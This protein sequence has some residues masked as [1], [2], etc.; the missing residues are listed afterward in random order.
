MLTLTLVPIFGLIAMVTD[1]G[2]M[3][4]LKMTAQTAAEAAAQATIIDMHATFGGAT[5]TCA[6]VT[7]SA[8]QTTCP[9]NITTPTNSIQRGCMY[10]QKHGFNSAD[11]WA[12]YQA[13]VSGMPPTMSGMGTASYWVTFRAIQT[14]P[15]MFSAIL[16]NTTG[17]V[18]A[19]ST[20]A[21]LGA[22]D[23]IYSLNPNASGAISA[24]GS[25]S[26]TSACGIYVNSNNAQ[27]LTTS[28]SATIS[29]PEY[30]VAGGVSTH[31]PLSPAANTGV[32]QISD[33]LASLPVPATA[34]YICNHVNYSAPNWSNPTLNPGV[35][36]GGISIGNNSYTLNPGTYILVGGGLS[37]QNA[38]STI[39]GT[40]VMFYNTYNGTYS[41][42]GIS[43]SANS[44]VSIKAPTTGTYAGILF[45][46]DRSA[47][48]TSDNYG[49]GG[50]ATY[51]GVIYAKNA[52]ITMD[53]NS[54]IT[55]NYTLII[56]DTISLIGASGINNNYSALPNGSPI[57]KTVVIE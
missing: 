49:G 56:A 35:Y 47:P 36:C 23:C 15:T 14:V 6:T 33:P 17:M 2:Y 31:S 19:R 44:N 20:T 10:A 40:G 29:A 16:G 43:I 38:N 27:A 54:S 48:A 32:T 9:Q 24:G 51:E 46:E 30:D 55:A 39:T 1:I 42:A 12:T 22:S 13:G 3:H 7:C 8:N 37:T 53:G 34:P 21:I 26:I 41:Y 11:R 5:L 25:A 18:V 52:A 28:G 57:Q 45:F 4:Y 50:T